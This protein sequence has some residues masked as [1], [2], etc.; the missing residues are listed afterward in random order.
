MRSVFTEAGATVQAFGSTHED[1]LMVRR[2]RL[3]FLDAPCVF[4]LKGRMEM[5][6]ES[7]GSNTPSMAGTLECLANRGRAL[8]DSYHFDWPES[9]Q[10]AVQ[11]LR[12]LVGESREAAGQSPPPAI[13]RPVLAAIVGGASAGKSTI[14]NNLLAGRAA[15]RVTAWG[16]TTRGP[17]LAAHENHRP[18]LQDRVAAGR[19]FAELRCVFS[20]LDDNA[21]GEPDRLTVVY[22]AIDALRPVLLFDLP[23]ITT[24]LSRAEGD[25]A[26]HRLAWFDRLIVVLDP[27]RWFD[28]QSLGGL[29]AESV[30]FG[31]ERYVAFNRAAEGG[32]DEGDLARLREQADRLGAL[33]MGV[34][35]S[36]RG[37][38]LCRFA[39][40][41]LD[42]L[43]AFL[44][45]PPP[46]RIP[47]LSARAAEA[48]RRVL[49]QN[50][51]RAARLDRL[52]RTLSTEALAGLPSA[53]D[54]MGALMTAPER[55][56]L[57]PMARVLRLDAH[58]RWLA[59]QTRR[60]RSL[61]AD[62]PLVGALT[63]RA[64]PHAGPPPAAAG[65][66]ETA[67]RFF[68]FWAGR[69][70]HEIARYVEGS[71]FWNEVRSWTG[72]GPAASRFTW[73]AAR[74]DAVARAAEGVDRALAA[75]TAKVEAE[76]HG[77]APHVKGA[78]GAG[79]LA[80]AVVLVAVPGPV[81]ALTLV[82]AKAAL[83]A[84][85]PQW[86]AAAGLGAVL[87]RHAGRLA[88]VFREKLIGGPEFD[89]VRQAADRFRVLLESAGRDLVQARLAEAEALVLS[90]DDALHVALDRLARAAEPRS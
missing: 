85:L 75:W 40:G 19:F 73:D 4:E 8:Q 43:A 58:Q 21:A 6:G 22:H 69:Q 90:A 86:L 34:F 70:A 10:Q 24:E 66:R 78:L 60:L 50:D 52:R 28:R 80:L 67:D 1:V 63:G 42:G 54:C 27:E 74:R 51:E 14:F 11:C 76:C 37:R 29:R 17:V 65:R 72:R 30:R 20:E 13:P 81:T 61:L 35:E 32:L 7:S 87:G 53:A 31:Q 25:V 33:D 3:G 64:N 26:L 79:A 12:F 2:K 56:L 16:H 45:R 41:A 49:D 68:E 18:W 39:P 36:R 82:A 44:V 9:V 47:I 71:L 38:G 84:A 23:D 48:A 55:R 59:A 46:H 88:E 57:E 15:S 5:E 89:A 83:G 62:V 77:M